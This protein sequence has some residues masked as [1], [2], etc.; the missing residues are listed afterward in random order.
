MAVPQGRQAEGVLSKKCWPRTPLGPSE[1]RMG[2]M[3][4]RSMVAVCHQPLPESWSEA[5]IRGEIFRCSYSPAVRATFSST[6]SFSRSAST[7]I[8][9]ET[10]LSS[11]KCFEERKPRSKY[12][13]LTTAEVLLRNKSTVTS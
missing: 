1:S 2:F 3:P 8:L 10:E 7:S 5:D 9:T 6:V 13:L 4:R 11:D 12:R